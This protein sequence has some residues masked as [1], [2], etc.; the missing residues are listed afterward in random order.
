MS[1]RASSRVYNQVS[2]EAWF[3]RIVHDWESYFSEE[4][5]RKGQE[6][7]RKGEISGIELSEKDAIVHCTF[8][9]KDTCYVV[10][11]WNGEKPE[12]RFSKEDAL[13]GNA[14]AVGGL[15]E[16]EELITDEIAPLPYVP[17]IIE[18][19]ASVEEPVP[20]EDHAEKG[21][22]PAASETRR[23]VPHFN[24][25]GSSLKMRAQ[26]EPSLAEKASSL[27]GPE[28]EL[29]VRLTALA[30]EAGFEYKRK[31]EDFL[32][33]DPDS[34]ATFFTVSVKRW[35]SVFGRLEFGSEA[36]CLLEGVKQVRLNGSVKQRGK[37]SM[38]IDWR[39]KVG[40]R[41]LD[42][43]YVSR[44]ARVGRGTHIVKGVGLVR[45]ADDQ[46]EMFNEWQ[47]AAASGPA[48]EWPRYMIFSLFSDHGVKIDLERALQDWREKIE[49]NSV[50]AKV[51]DDKMLP[52]FLRSYQAHGV[53]WM[54]NLR[55]QKCHGLLADEMGLG[56]TLQ[57]LTLLN[58]YPFE[59]KDSLVVCP[60]S[61]VPVW[62]QEAKHWYPN[63][64]VIVLRSR[65]TF[66]YQT[67]SKPKLWIAS[68]TQLRRHKHLLSETNFGYAIL[69]EAQQ[70]KNP[71]AK[72]TH[73][74]CAIRAECRLALTGTPI[75]NRLLDMWTLFRF[76]MPGL[77]GSRRR[78]EEAASSAEPLV[79]SSLEQTLRKQIAPFLLRRNKDKV[80]NDLPPKVEMDL[81]CPVTDTQRQVYERL[82]NEAS[83]TMGDDLQTIVSEQS[84]N[85]FTLLTRLR[86]T[87][88]DPGLVPG[89]SADPTQSGKIQMLLT[90]LGEALTGKGARKVVIFS[91]FV[92][93]LNRV[94]PLIKKE[95]PEARILELTG[96]TKNRSKPVKT[97]QEET[98]AT[99]I[100]VSL[101]A[102]GTGITL[103]AADYVFLLD[104]WWN[105]AIED[106]A[107]D[108]VHRI[109]QQKRVFVYRMLTK[110]TIEERIQQL[111][112]EKQDLFESTLSDL[113]RTSDLLQ[114]FDDLRE[115][116][117]FVEH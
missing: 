116:V 85:F 15:Y 75:E 7:Y 64:N 48:K 8:T 98:G 103:H 32:M 102:G 108:R 59:D 78:F 42:P 53:R 33:S 50:S 25:V 17:K 92:K 26:W 76:L 38:S 101:R 3:K 84:M 1:T 106:Q 100:L 91:Q 31:S 39:L 19:S 10:L 51:L 28:R 89:V 43:R 54:A 68:Y 61:V 60:A 5:L 110:G 112:S 45:I 55:M 70:I 105:P 20:T 86:Q 73:A 104:P 2:L 66:A 35:E 107:V 47:V 9:R 80:G 46:A 109:G 57:V 114:H 67:E 24:I 21:L 90:R 99:V 29:L 18:L 37:D 41:W 87:C 44:L 88:C 81:V 6:I 11:E 23:L 30:K 96:Q 34:V 22:V 74:C 83:D 69:D 49:S 40:K 72:V 12:I 27:S 58:I 36:R 115:L 95:F 82:L 71:D 62:E 77:L 93:L 111:K 14:V 4:A 94:K 63:L 13:L 56:K 79:H 16:I 52:D 65:Q 113:G 97:F 117:R